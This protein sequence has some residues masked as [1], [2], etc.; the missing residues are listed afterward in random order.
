M[1]K[2]GM[3]NQNPTDRNESRLSYGRPPDIRL[4][5]PTIGFV[6]LHLLAK[7]EN[8]S[9]EACAPQQGCVLSLSTAARAGERNETGRVEAKKVEATKKN[10]AFQS[11]TRDLLICAC[12]HAV[13]LGTSQTP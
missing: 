8:G 10:A 3:P 2:F 7:K 12:L 4:A 6:C 9:A 13:R 11:R 1:S 5:R